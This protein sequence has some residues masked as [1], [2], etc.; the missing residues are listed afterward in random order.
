MKFLK[1]FVII[2]LS[3]TAVFFFIGFISPTFEYENKVTIN[4][5]VN[6]VFSYFINPDNLKK[7]MEGLE[8]VE[9]IEGMPLTAGSKYNLIIMQKKDSI[10][11]TEEVTTFKPN[12]VFA[13]HLYNRVIDCHATLT[14]VASGRSTV[15]TNHDVVEGKGVFFRSLLSIMRSG[16][17]SSEQHIYE[18][19]KKAVEE[20]PM[21]SQLL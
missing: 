18:R 9:S 12:A 1:Y 4:R 8:R 3:L 21:V 13:F 20:G 7:W 17:H 14:F 15:F 11:V 6:E 10:T 2:L 5:P 16:L 19:F